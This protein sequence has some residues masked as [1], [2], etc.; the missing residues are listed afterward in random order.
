MASN[1][2]VDMIWSYIFFSLADSTII[3]HLSAD[4]RM[5]TVLPVL[6]QHFL[7]G[8]TVHHSNTTA[9]CW[10][11]HLQG[12]RQ[13]ECSV[14]DFSEV[15]KLPLV[16]CLEGNKKPTHAPAHDSS[17]LPAEVRLKAGN[18]EY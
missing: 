5:H 14:V 12:I 9:A 7:H 3:A 10:S 8:N 17:R 2:C 1:L 11:V 13:G 16:P 15:S 18:M 4:W 6:W